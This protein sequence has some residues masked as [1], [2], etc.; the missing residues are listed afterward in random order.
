MYN[1]TE[2]VFLSGGGIMF[3]LLVI[4]SVFI[5]F[6]I[7]MIIKFHVRNKNKPTLVELALIF[8]LTLPLIGSFLV[9]W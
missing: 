6:I 5:W 2:K 7:L 9:L 3:E 8:M 1:N 4:I